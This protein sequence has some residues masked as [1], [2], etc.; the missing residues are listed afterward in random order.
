MGVRVVTEHESSGGN[1]PRETLEG[2]VVDIA[3][4]RKYPQDELMER[5]SRHTAK[6]ALMGH[7]IESGY[8]LM[9]QDRGLQ[10]LDTKATQHVVRALEQRPNAKGVRLRAQREMRHK[11]ME[12]VRVETA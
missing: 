1:E 8:A 4:V 9:D 5:A 10:L 7:C 11:E 6:C 3:C 12:T 2:Y